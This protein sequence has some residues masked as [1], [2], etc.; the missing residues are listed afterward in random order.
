MDYLLLF[1]IYTLVYAQGKN[2]YASAFAFALLV[3]CAN[4]ILDK[5]KK[6]QNV[7]RLTKLFNKA[8][9]E[10]AQKK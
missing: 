7:L 5:Y 8:L 3:F 9:Y 6:K 10:N 1:L 2:P 4:Y